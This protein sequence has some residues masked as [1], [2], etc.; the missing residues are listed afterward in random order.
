MTAPTCETCKWGEM[1]FSASWGEKKLR[2]MRAARFRTG[3]YDEVLGIGRSAAFERDSLPEPHRWP[4]DKCLRE[5]VNWEE[6]T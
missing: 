1:I 3:E 2:C 4:G 5:G 6:R